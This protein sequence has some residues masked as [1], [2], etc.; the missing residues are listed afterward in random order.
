MGGD[1]RKGAEG[2]AARMVFGGEFKRQMHAAMEGKLGEHHSGELR[3]ERAEAKAERI[4]AEELSRLGWEESDLVARRKSDPGKLRIAARLRQETTRT[5]KVI[6]SRVQL[7][8][9]RSAQVRLYEWVKASEA[10]KQADC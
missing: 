7:G 1:G 4:V 9:S 8:S 6:A 3:R 2:L 10:T 5:I